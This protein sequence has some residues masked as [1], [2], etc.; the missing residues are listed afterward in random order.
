MELPGIESF[1]WVYFYTFLMGLAFVV[2]YALIVQILLVSYI[3]IGKF[4]NSIYSKRKNDENILKLKEEVFGC[5]ITDNTISTLV[6]KSLYDIEKGMDIKDIVISYS[7]VITI[8]IYQKDF[9]NDEVRTSLIYN[10]NDIF[11]IHSFKLVFNF[12]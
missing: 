1:A 8:T 9:I 7:D 4:V 2:S 5:D 10:F 11:D 3:L 6:E 12:E